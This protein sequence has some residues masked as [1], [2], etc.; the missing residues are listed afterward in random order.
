M[1]GNPEISTYTPTDANGAIPLRVIVD[2]EKAPEE[3]GD[4]QLGDSLLGPQDVAILLQ[5]GLTSVMKSSTVVQLNQR[6]LL[7]LICSQ[8][9]SFAIAVLAEIGM[10][11]G[12]GEPRSLTSALMA[13]LELD[14]TAFKPEHQVDMH[15]LLESWL[16]GIRIPRRED[17]MAGGRWA[18]Q[19]YYDSIFAV[20]K[21]ILDDAET[22]SALKGHIQRSRHALESDPIPLP[23][24]ESLER[25]ENIDSRSN[26]RLMDTINQA[27]RLIEEADLLGISALESLKKAELRTTDL[28]NYSSIVEAYEAA[29]AACSNVVEMDKHAFHAPWFGKFFK[30][31][32]DALMIKSMYDNAMNDVDDV[33]HWLHALRNGAMAKES[34]PMKTPHTPQTNLSDWEPL[35]LDPV[36]EVDKFFIELE[37]HAEQE[38][39]DAIIEATIYEEADRDRLRNDPLVRLLI[40]NPPGKYN[41]TIVSAMG[42]ITDGKKGVELKDA[43]KRLEEER[44]VQVI[45]ADTGTARSLE[46]NASKIEDAIFEASKRQRPFGLLGYSQG[47]AN[48]LMTETIMLSGTPTQRAV[49]TCPKAGLVSRQLLFS[50]ANGSVHGP[51]TSRKVQKLIVMCEEFFKYQ[52]GYVSRALASSVLEALNGIL[53]SAAFHKFMGGVQVF[54]TDGCRSFWRESQQL[55]RFPT[56]Y[57]P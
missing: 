16:P 52:Q 7:D 32:Y 27:K 5:S 22:Y 44:G 51:A 25:G 21:S 45:R 48:I 23:K 28:A 13:L 3:T 49:I 53:D 15:S 55:V 46:Y 43:F 42:V 26:E 8:P 38:I 12:Q 11:S 36:V 20:S 18:R 14:Q 31:N 56:H 35:E 9:R 41:F 6:M 4:Y 39:V 30:R 29:F 19:S 1:S 2:A 57:F 33:R 17:Y 24:E 40:P 34:Q 47:C 54:M 37:K 50:A 10:P